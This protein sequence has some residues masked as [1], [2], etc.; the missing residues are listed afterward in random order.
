MIVADNV[1]SFYSSGGTGTQIIY[2]L[3]YA[4]LD[5]NL[6]PDSLYI[7]FLNIGSDEW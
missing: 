2:N 1:N 4:M 7:P 6:N 3:I 5:L